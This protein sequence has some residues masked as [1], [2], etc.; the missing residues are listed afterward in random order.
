[1]GF[2]EDSIQSLP[3][4]IGTNDVLD[5]IACAEAAIQTGARLTAATPVSQKVPGSLMKQSLCLDQL[6]LTPCTVQ[7]QIVQQKAHRE[8]L[9]LSSLQCIK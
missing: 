9:L 7:A 4:H 5:C 1:M 6:L 2:G 3:G 8:Q